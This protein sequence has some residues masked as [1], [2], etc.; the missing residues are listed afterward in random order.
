MLTLSYMTISTPGTNDDGKIAAAVVLPAVEGAN[1]TI[2]S[3]IEAVDDVNETVP[4]NF[5]TVDQVEMIVSCS[6]FISIRK[7]QTVKLCILK[8][9]TC[10]I[11]VIRRR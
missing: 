5:G 11:N 3:H 2:V 10:L 8:Y 9:L 6:K 7:I 1:N 4:R